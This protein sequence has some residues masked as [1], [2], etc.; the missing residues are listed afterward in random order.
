IAASLGRDEFEVAKIAYGLATTGII[1][2]RQPVRQTQEFDTTRV[3]SR[4]ASARVS[5][6][7]GRHSEAADELRHAIQEDPLT[8]SVHAE[9]GFA[10]ARAGD[11]AGARASWEHVLRLAPEDPDSERVRAALDLLLRFE[12]LLT[13]EAN[14]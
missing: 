9:L 14:G 7:S 11:L 12:H 2:M 13:E 10:S 3:E 4:R 5:T 6:R 8:P 1:S